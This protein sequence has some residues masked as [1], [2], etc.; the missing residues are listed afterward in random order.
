VAEA[1]ANGKEATDEEVQEQIL[2]NPVFHKDGLFNKNYYFEILRQNRLNSVEYEAGLRASITAQNMWSSVVEGVTLT[3]DELWKEF[4]LANSSFTF[5][6]AAF[7]PANFIDNSEP[8]QE[9][10]KK[11]YD[12]NSF[13]FTV[14]TEIKAFYV[15]AGF[16]DMGEKIEIPEED[17]LK[18][19]EENSYDYL[20]EKE[21]RASHIL[22]S[23]EKGDEAGAAGAEEKAA[24]ILARLKAGE[25]F[26]KLAKESSNDPGS[27][28]KGGDLGFF[29]LGTMVTQFEDAAFSLN[30]GE[31]SGLVKTSFGYHI[32]KVTDIK[33]EGVK[34]LSKVRGKIKAILLKAQAVFAATDAVEGLKLA[35]EG[36]GDIEELEKAVTDAGLAP[37][38][39]D[40]ISEDGV[41][42]I[43]LTDR[44]LKNAAFGLN[45]GGV[46]A[47]VETTDGIY[48]IK[49]IER[50]ESHVAPFDEALGPVKEAFKSEMAISAARVA[51]DE[52]LKKILAKE[53]F[54]P[55]IK[56]KGLEVDS[57]T[58]VIRE[59]AFIKEIGLYIGDMKGFFELT[60]EEPYYPE[61][62][63]HNNVFYLFSFDNVKLAERVIFDANIIAIRDKYI[64]IKRAEKQ[65]SWITGL[66]E[67][68]EITVNQDFL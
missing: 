31:L 20:T 33:E 36:D 45:T 67:K 23:F 55:L 44:M 47:P 51:A 42:G 66:R 8:P 29:G 32:I 52:V 49:V 6:Y 35:F 59:Q 3:D 12:K 13:D 28:A 7:D 57:T 2:S 63:V 22:I 18:Y 64:N 26:A 17:I 21:V 43:L 40:F 68:A 4:E 37:V 9:E 11:F 54:E 53:P 50:V 14:P 10:L 39:T 65:N 62:V 27:A 30:K 16:K 58:E 24:S 61:V 56:E 48:L 38:K 25:S 34:A 19:Y 41:A 15:K 60:K 46:S 1:R 5:D